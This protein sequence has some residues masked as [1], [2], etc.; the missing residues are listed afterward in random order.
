MELTRDY[1]KELRDS[2]LLSLQL[3]I[4]ANRDIT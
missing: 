4:R 2:I 1:I 3:V